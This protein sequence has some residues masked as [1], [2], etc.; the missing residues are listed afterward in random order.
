MAELEGVD[1]IV[2]GATTRGLA[3]TFVLSTLGHRA[4]LLERSPNLGGG[5]GSFLTAD[6]SRFEFGMHVLDDMRSEATTRLFKSVVDGNVHRV[7]LKRA[8]VLRNHI[9][10]YAPAPAEMPRELRELLRGDELV[11]DLGEALPTRDRLAEFYG[12]AYVDMI[13]DEVLPS[14]PSEHRHAAFGV[15]EGELLANIYPWFFPRARRKAKPGDQSR[16]FHDKLRDGVPQYVLYPREGGFGGFSQG[17]VRHFDAGRIEVLSGLGDLEIEVERDRHRIASIEAAGRRFGADR[18][19]WAASWPELC[20]LLRLP[21]QETAT[22]R[23]LIGSFRFNR[24]I[25]TDFHEILVG[26]PAHCINRLYRPAAFRESDEPLIQIEYAFP[27]ADERPLQSAHWLEIWLRNLRAL[28]LIEDTHRVEM[29]DFKTRKM[30]FNSFGMEGERLRD[31]DPMLLEPDSNIYP[32]TPSM[33]NLNL[34]AHIPSDLEYV[35]SVAGG[36]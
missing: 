13:F 4:V 16:A 31:A 32:V 29:F 18:Y 28:G 19:F 33:A 14:Y 11:D 25:L 22:D 34:N 5:D 9:I 12:R 3:A 36:S 30:H 7:K 10:P 6:G 23:V 21:C 35:E 1:A 24:P 27:C 26:D 2:I 17:F 15:E 8:I 20:R